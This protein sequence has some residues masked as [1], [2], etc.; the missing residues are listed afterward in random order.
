MPWVTRW[1]GSCSHGTSTAPADGTIRG[2][3]GHLEQIRTWFG[4]PLWEMPPAA[5]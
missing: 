5:L 2:A 1:P 4:R 3:V